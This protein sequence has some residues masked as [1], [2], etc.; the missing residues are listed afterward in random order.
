[1]NGQQDGRKKGRMDDDE[2]KEARKEGWVIEG[3]KGW[4]DDD[5]E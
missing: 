4:M 5:D 3:W 1:M 2:R